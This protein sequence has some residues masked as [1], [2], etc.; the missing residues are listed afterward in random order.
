MDPCDKLRLD[1]RD[2]KAERD[3]ELATARLRFW[4]GL[5]G[6][7]FILDWKDLD[8]IERLIAIF[9]ALLM[10]GDI[11]LAVRFLYRSL[12]EMAEEVGEEAAEK[13]AKK[14]GSRLLGLIA[15][16]ILIYDIIS[17]LAEWYEM[18]LDIENRFRNAVTRLYTQT[19]CRERDA[20][21]AAEGVSIR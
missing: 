16:A 20:V 21:F 9:F 4:L 18:Q 19:K 3:R 6:L 8:E 1:L 12:F 13:V 7:D 17:G 10:A 14:L 15:L 2:A 5:L 11:R